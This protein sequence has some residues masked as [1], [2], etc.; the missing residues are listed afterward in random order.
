MRFRLRVLVTA[1]LLCAGCGVNPYHIGP[2]VAGVVRLTA[3]RS[4]AAGNPVG[5]TITTTADGAR[6]WLIENG[7]RVDSELT[8]QGAYAFSVTKG[9]ACRTLV[10]V[11]PALTDTSMEFTPTRDV[12]TDLDTLSLTRTGVLSS[13]PNPFNVQAHLHFSVAIGG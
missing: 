2:F 6:V 3:M 1:L 5:L 9:R 8:I 13:T 12:A 7:A 11:P 4:D 10:G